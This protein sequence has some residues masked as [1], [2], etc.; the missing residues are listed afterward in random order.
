MLNNFLTFSAY[1][2]ETRSYSDGQAVQFDSE[3]INLGSH[4]DPSSSVFIGPTDGYYMF[5]MSFLGDG[6]YVMHAEIVVGGAAVAGA[7]AGSAHD[8][9][10]NTVV[11]HCAKGAEVFVRTRGN[12]CIMQGDAT[13]AYSMFT[14]T[15][16]SIAQI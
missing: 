16:L 9:A 3:V 13:F 15:L 12:G 2:T 8:F 7:A 10:S 5:S 6:D 11:V 4:Y 14:G 1:A